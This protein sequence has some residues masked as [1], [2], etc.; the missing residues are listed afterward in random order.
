MFDH[1]VGGAYPIETPAKEWGRIKPTIP[2]NYH[3]QGTAMWAM[4]K[5]M[6]R[7]QQ[8]LDTQK[9]Y[10]LIGNIHD[11]ILL[12]FPLVDKRTIK[13]KVK[14]IKRLME[15][16]GDDIGVPLPVSVEYHFSNWS[17][18]TEEFENV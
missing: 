9:D 15:Q 11:E 3:V 8:F 10:Y 13:A 17:E 14:K 7:V 12:D 6:N 4:V 1:D 2:L 5:A 18:G 16:S